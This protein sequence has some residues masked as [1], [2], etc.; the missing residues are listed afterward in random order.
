MEHAPVAVHFLLGQSIELSLKG[1]LQTRWVSL[2]DLRDV[3]RH[4][5]SK[6]LEGAK[7][8]GLLEL[9][10]MTVEELDAIETLDGPYASKDLQY[11]EVGAMRLPEYTHIRSA[12]LRL[13]HGLAPLVGISA[14]GLPQPGRRETGA[15][16]EEQG[17]EAIAAL[18]EEEDRRRSTLQYRVQRALRWLRRQLGHLLPG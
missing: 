16:S 7:A 6:C 10:A 2:E 5:L 13:V 12:A 8:R 14:S 18:L 17:A 4:K 1:F 11:I 9:V 15:L 3:Y